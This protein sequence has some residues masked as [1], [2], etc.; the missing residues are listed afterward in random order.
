MPT[1]KRCG[2]ESAGNEAIGGIPNIHYLDFFSRGRGQVV[3]LLWEDASIAYDDTRYTFEE[4]P[5]YKNSRIEQM[6]PATTVPVIELNGR[7]LTQSYAVLRHFARQLGRYD[8]ETDEEKYW[9]DAMCDIVI[10]CTRPRLLNEESSLICMIRAHSLR[11]SLF[12]R[13]QGRSLP[14]VSKN[15]S[16]KVPESSGD[17]SEN[18]QSID[19][20][21]VRHWEEYHICGFGALSV[22]PR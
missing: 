5:E 7:I 10:D 19:I 16:T 18:Q 13:Q 6:N 14:R 21:S 4:Y 8:G 22:V 2:T 1:S 17:A 3:R 15:G 12:G 9:A 20:R 11:P